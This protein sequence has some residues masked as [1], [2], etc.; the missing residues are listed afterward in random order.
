MEV[1]FLPPH[2][3]DR[4]RQLHRPRVRADVPP[5][6]QRGHDRRDGAAPDR[7]RGRG[8][9]PRP[10]ARSSSDEGIVVRTG[11]RVHRGREDAAGVRVGR[12]LQGRRARRR[13]DRTCC[14]PSGRRPNTDD[15]GLDRAGVAVDA[16]GYVTVDDELRTNVPGDLGARRLQRPR[17]LH[18]HV[19]QR[20]R[21]RRRQPARRRPAARR[22]T[23]S[24][25]TASSST[26]R[27]GRVGM[28]EARPR[29]GPA[30]R[31]S[32]ASGR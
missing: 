11:R 32:S 29:A 12:R 19:L 5:L 14:S 27:S 13:R 23:A 3:V 20:L 30:A 26:R 31:C 2:L 22:A 16:R 18:P 7:A 17:R 25:P 9:R 24:R 1:D 21:D 15:L 8:R 6:R 4:R 28:T 10:S